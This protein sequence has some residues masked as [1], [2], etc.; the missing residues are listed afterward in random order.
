MLETLLQRLATD[1]ELTAPFPKSDRGGFF[2]QLNPDLAI[3][4]EGMDPGVFFFSQVAPCPLKKQEE[5]FSQLMRANFL[6]QGTGG[7]VIGL[8]EDEKFLTLSS[9]LPY[10]MNYNTFKE[11][12]G[13]FANFVD[14]WRE[15][16]LKHHEI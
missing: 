11:A 9:Y 15:E 4:V 2:L 12:L 1:L 6:G 13:D 7:G 5:I 14:Y 8:D 10:D 16:I 3:S